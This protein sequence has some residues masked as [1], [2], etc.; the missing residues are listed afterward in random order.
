MSLEVNTLEIPGILRIKGR[1]VEYA[2][3]VVIFLGVVNEIGNS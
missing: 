3:L 2:E 1:I